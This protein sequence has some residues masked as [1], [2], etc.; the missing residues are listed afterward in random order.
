MEKDLR[1]SRPVGTREEKESQRLESSLRDSSPNHTAQQ[2]RCIFLD[3]LP[4]RPRI[5]IHVSLSQQLPISFDPVYV[6]GRV[7]VEVAIPQSIERF[8]RLSELDF[9]HSARVG[10]FGVNEVIPTPP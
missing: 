3:Q 7:C 9:S 10:V 8:E 5:D 2:P 4:Q 1:S 6:E